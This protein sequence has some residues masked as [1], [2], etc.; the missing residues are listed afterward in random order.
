M[1]ISKILKSLAMTSSLILAACNSGGGGSSYNSAGIGGGGV[2]ADFLYVTSQKYY[3]T[4]YP[5]TGQQ[6][7]EATHCLSTSPNGQNNWST[8]RCDKHA[9]G[10]IADEAGNVFIVNGYYSY[11]EKKGWLATTA[12]VTDT[13]GNQI[14]TTLQACTQT[15]AD[16]YNPDL[17]S[18]TTQYAFTAS[19][20]R[21]RDGKIF[22]AGNG[23][24]YVP[25]SASENTE[26]TVNLLDPMYNKIKGGDY[27]DISGGGVSD[28]GTMYIAANYSGVFKEGNWTNY[29]TQS[30]GNSSWTVYNNSYLPLTGNSGTES[31]CRSGDIWEYQNYILST[32][33]CAGNIEGTTSIAYIPK[34]SFNAEWTT[35]QQSIPKDS[36]DNQSYSL[37]NFLGNTAY[38]VKTVQLSTNTIEQVDIII[39]QI[40]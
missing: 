26:W 36:P 1:K 4:F 27:S 15:D 11:N 8:V 33:Y 9:L 3:A 19:Q 17:P 23:W 25:V 28:D 24:L 16:R 30:N 12:W 20:F 2:S 32:R 39:P 6:Q 38:A 22:V 7:W 13:N 5:Q 10:Y 37:Y 14:G 31:L 18:C 34:N 35:V 29:L 40:M 21:V